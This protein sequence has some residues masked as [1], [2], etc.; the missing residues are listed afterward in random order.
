MNESIYNVISSAIYCYIATV[1]KF[2]GIKPWCT[3][4]IVLVSL[5][6]Q[7]AMLVAFLLPIKVVI[8]LGNPNI[9]SYFPEAWKTI[10]RDQLVIGLAITAGVF[11]IISLLSQKKISKDVKAYSSFMLIRNEKSLCMLIRI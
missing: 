4:R 8:L 1:K 7:A 5:L 9:P 3:V 10:S 2:M 6:S 11:F